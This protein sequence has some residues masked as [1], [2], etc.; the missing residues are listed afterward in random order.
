M[1]TWRL[2]AS[3]PRNL[4][5]SADAR[6][7][8]TDYTDDH[9]WELTL[10]GGE[11]SALSLQTTFGLRA[12][13]FRMFPRFRGSEPGS[14]NYASILDP[15]EFRTA[16]TIELVYPNYLALTFTPLPGI[17]V[18]AEYWVPQSHAVAGLVQVTNGASSRRKIQVDWLSILAPGVSS[19]AGRAATSR[20][21]G[22]RM[23]AQEIDGCMALAG[24]TGNLHPV[25]FLTGGAMPDTP[26]YPGLT[27]TYELAPGETCQFAWAQAALA[28]RSASLNLARSQA[29]LLIS[30]DWEALRA[31][32]IMSNANQVEI[33][34]GDPDWDIAFHL[35]QKTARSLIVGPTGHLPERTFVQV[36]QPDHGF[37]LRGDGSD[38]SHL[39]SG[40]PALDAYFLADLLLPGAA[41]LA[42]G[43][44]VNFLAT[45]GDQ[46]GQVNW[47]AGPASQPGRRLAFPILAHLAWRIYAVSHDQMFLQA[48]YPGLLAFI[49]EWLSNRHDRDQDG[50]P[51]W[52]DPLQ[53][54]FDEHPLFSR[55]TGQAVG[56]DITT[57][58]S[59]ALAALL[60]SECRALEDIAACLGLQ[61][62]MGLV[63]RWEQLQQAAQAGWDEA[64][65]CYRLRDRD[66]HA[67]PALLLLGERLGAG[68]IPVQ[69]EFDPPARL[70]VEI[71]IGSAEEQSRHRSPVA[72]AYG[73]IAGPRRENPRSSTANPRRFIEQL[74]AEKFSWDPERGIFT[75]DR[76]YSYIEKL[77]VQELGPADRVRVYRAGCQELDISLL[78]PVW[79]GLADKTQ[80]TRLVGE[81]ITNP[82]RFWKPAGLVLYAS[83][84]GATAPESDRAAEVV[85]LPWNALVGAG[86]VRQGFR[87]EAAELL[88]RLMPAI[89]E[90]LKREGAFYQRYR[91]EDGQ[92]TGEKNALT[93][94]PPVGF[95]LETLGVRLSEPRTPG[96]M[97][98]IELTGFNPF[99]WPVT[100]KYRG[101]TIVRQKKKTIVI[102]P[103]GQTTEVDA[104]SDTWPAHSLRI[105]YT[106]GVTQP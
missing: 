103:D 61:L 77:D 76:L 64:G 17:D 35:A 18:K 81:T 15:N 90:T 57:I 105:A 14:A 28:E 20:S 106:A 44:L 91:A 75:G 58:E 34:T 30:Q 68:L 7:G 39:W 56:L 22:E 96:Q 31:H 59:P 8:E 94:L 100:V 53:A 1:R 102:F 9:I 72:F 24:R 98:E 99:P 78:L 80:A 10:G 2:T 82:A 52:D 89:I 93:G 83:A 45:A 25:I 101:V 86:L 38:Y 40:Q 63:E 74:P 49:Q 48:V 62:P 55:S 97:P 5:I 79:A 11:P 4:V 71:Q 41:S 67:T 42:Q 104:D 6:L 51:E 16:P 69:Q 36:R 84:P 27:L 43:F 29:S 46:P 26:I 88:Q 21:N 47:R 66:S 23:A 70:L 13:S 50:L 87:Q 37:S 3:D 85:D 32:L 92:G 54:G 12:R 60:A 65:G 73:R 19:G 33:Y 95:F